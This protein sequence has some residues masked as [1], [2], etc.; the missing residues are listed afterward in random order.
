MVGLVAP[1]SKLIRT[2]LV[3]NFDADNDERE[4]V[5]K[6]NKQQTE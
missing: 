3:K 4:M 1:P 2:I 6:L 5:H